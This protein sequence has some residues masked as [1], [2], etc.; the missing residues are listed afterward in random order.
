MILD[1]LPQSVVALV[2]R[3]LVALMLA[4]TLADLAELPPRAGGMLNNASD[5]ASQS[6]D[7]ARDKAARHTGARQLRFLQ[8]VDN[9]MK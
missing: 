1:V 5:Q 9:L 4:A 6:A 3:I 2:M 7:V 8:R